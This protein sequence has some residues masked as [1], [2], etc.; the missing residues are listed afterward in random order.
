MKL[1]GVT[2]AGSREDASRPGYNAVYVSR[3]TRFVTLKNIAKAKEDRPSPTHKSASSRGYP[4]SGLL[5][6]IASAF[7]RH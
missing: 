2:L 5:R 4:L 1:S 3:V 6:K 7:L